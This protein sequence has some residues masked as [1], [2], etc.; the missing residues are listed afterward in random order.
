[1]QTTESFWRGRIAEAITDSASVPFTLKVSK[2]PNNENQFITISPDTE[3][4]EIFYYTTKTW[5]AGEAGTLNITGR[6]YDPT[7][8]TQSAWDQK[9][10]VLNIDY[11]LALNH[12]IINGKASLDYDNVHTADVQ[13]TWTDT[14]GL[15]W[16]NNLTDTQRDLLSPNN[17]AL[18]YN[19]TDN[20]IQQYV[21]W[22][23]TEV[24]DTW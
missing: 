9:T 11:K 8:S 4:E 2:V 7:D 10:H 5:T 3:N 13:Y 12:I 22:A 17:W 24:G 23:W 19:T 18:I 14:I 21:S 20:V 6:G 15:N 1:M 16:L